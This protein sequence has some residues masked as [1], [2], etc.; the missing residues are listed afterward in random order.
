MITEEDFTTI[1]DIVGSDIYIG[2][3]GRGT[4]TSA[5]LWR[6]T[7]INTVNP[8]V[9]NYPNHNNQF[10]FVWDNRAGYTYD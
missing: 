6:I 8:I 1:I 7:H 9:I 5:S 3:A 10:K 2:K 4:P